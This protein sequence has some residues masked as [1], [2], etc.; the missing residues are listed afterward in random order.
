MNALAGVF[1]ALLLLV[2]VPIFMVF[3][4]GSAT[5]AIWGMNLP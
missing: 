1:S 4:L 2:S 3:G 5:T